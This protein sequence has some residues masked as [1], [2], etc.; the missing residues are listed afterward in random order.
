MK[1]ILKDQIGDYE[2]IHANKVGVFWFFLLGKSILG[3]SLDWRKI[4][5]HE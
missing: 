1:E 3:L 4:W 2:H 5:W